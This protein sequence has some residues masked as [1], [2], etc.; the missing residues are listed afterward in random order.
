[1]INLH[2]IDCMIALKEMQD[3]KFD[4]AI[5]DPP[6]R[7]SNENDMMKETRQNIKKGRLKDWP[8]KPKKE[9]FDELFRVS[10]NQI[11]WGVNNFN[12]SEYKGFFVWD[13]NIA[14]GMRFSMC[15]MAFI[16]EQ[17]G[18]TSK[19]WKFRSSGAEKRIHPT[20]KPVKLYEKLLMTYAKEGDK[21]LDTH[22][23]SGSSAIASHNLGYDF[24]GYEIDKDYFEAAKKRLEQHQAQ[25]TLF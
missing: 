5:V 7:N 9:Y 11:I 15:E 17:L 3:N 4:L 8:N 20:Q 25:K 1:M 6:Y 16:S 22:L 13:K 10:K 18:T 23:G 21:I 2:N 12:I 24:V 14:F 19:F